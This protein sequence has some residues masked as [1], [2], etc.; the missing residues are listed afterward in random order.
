M[1]PL[2]WAPTG[3]KYL[4]RMHDML[5]SA[6]QTSRRISSMK[7]YVTHRQAAHAGASGLVDGVQDTAR[8]EREGT[9]GPAGAPASPS[10]DP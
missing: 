7:S 3:L 1:R 5:F 9:G 6:L 4:S 10:K 8:G 2:G